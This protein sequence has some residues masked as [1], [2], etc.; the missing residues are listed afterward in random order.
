MTNI[1]I[2]S[3]NKINRGT[4]AHMVL[5]LDGRDALGTCEG[6]QVLAS[7]ISNSNK[8]LFQIGISISVYTFAPI[9]EYPSDISTIILTKYLC[10][11]CSFFCFNIFKIILPVND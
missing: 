9:S 7:E 1:E 4:E 6:K 11:N 10:R 5:I 8:Y 3:M 2:L